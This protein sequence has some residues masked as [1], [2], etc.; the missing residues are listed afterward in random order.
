M[1]GKS[2]FFYCV[3]DVAKYQLIVLYEFQ[4]IGFNLRC[5]TNIGLF[6]VKTSDPLSSDQGP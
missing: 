3:A 2:N 5:N 6:P 1:L 4:K